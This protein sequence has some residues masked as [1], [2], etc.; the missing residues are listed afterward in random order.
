MY[1]FFIAITLCLGGGGANG[2]TSFS[3]DLVFRTNKFLSTSIEER[4]SYSGSAFFFNNRRIVQNDL[5]E[6]VDTEGRT[7]LVRAFITSSIKRQGHGEPD[8]AEESL[9]FVFP[10]GVKNVTELSAETQIIKFVGDSTISL[11]EFVLGKNN[12]E[13]QK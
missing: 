13:P 7:L 10:E 3:A 11:C 8:T 2:A 6:L 9:Y 1:K 12:S 4:L 5:Y